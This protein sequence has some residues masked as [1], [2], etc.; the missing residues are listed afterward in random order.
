MLYTTLTI[1]SKDYK[2][3]LGAAN[4]MELEKQLGGNNPMDV[5]MATQNGQLPP[6]TATLRI[7]HGSMQKFQHGVSF[8][9]VVALYDDYVAE[10]NSYTD[11][12]PVLI[13]VFKVSGFFKVA[14]EAESSE[15]A[16]P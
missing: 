12:L 5:L 15:T 11:L 14:P 1:G 7:L 3:R 9:D 6:L 8:N 10:G 2:L 4:I 16:K 13:D